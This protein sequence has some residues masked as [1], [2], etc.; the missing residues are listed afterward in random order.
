DSD[1][2]GEKE[3]GKKEP[4]QTPDDAKPIGDPIRVSGKGRGRKRHY[5][6]FEFDGNQYS[7]EDP[8]MLVP[9]DKEQKPYVAIIK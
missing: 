8:V 4:P 5:E 2:D 7:L 6:S 9:E 3:E 1:D